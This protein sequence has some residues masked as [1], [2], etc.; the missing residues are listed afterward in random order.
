MKGGDRIG[1]SVKQTL[2]LDFFKNYKVLAGHGGLNNQ[3]QGVAIFDAPDGYLWTKHDEFVISSGYVFKANPNL[4]ETFTRSEEFTRIACL[5]IKIGRYIDEV[6]QSVLNAFNDAN[7]PLL[8]VD[9]KHSWMEVNNALLV[10]VMNKNIERFHLGQLRSSH[11]SNYSYQT[12]KTKKILS[13]LEDELSYPAMLYD[14]NAKKTYF[15]SDQFRALSKDLQL[16]DFWQPSFDFSKETLCNTL[17]M[18]RYRRFIEDYHKPYSWI[19]VPITVD[20]SVYAYFVVLEAHKIIDH[21]DQFALRTGFLLIQEIFEQQL[22]AQIMRGTAFTKFIKEITS[23]QLTDKSRISDYAYS[24]NLNVND[25]FYTVV[26]AQRDESICFSGYRDYINNSI[27]SLFSPRDCR[28]ALLDDAHCLLLFRKKPNIDSTTAIAE[29]LRALKKTLEAP[30]YGFIVT[31][32]FADIASSLYDLSKSYQRAVRTLEFGKIIY[33]NKYLW[34]YCELGP[35]A[36]FSMPKEECDLMLKDFADLIKDES[37]KTKLE[38]F[39]TYLDC[40][41]NYS[42]TAKT[43]YMHINTVRSHITKIVKQTNIDLNNPIERMKTEVLLH[44][45]LNPNQ[46]DW[47]K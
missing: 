25:D 35:F 36:W 16:D 13:A 1:I 44:L 32:G 43:C 46:S 8:I 22:M 4:F 33:P 3:I 37:Q 45:L 41:M 38:T 30:R 6:P 24:L 5:G 17:K 47:T 2:E 31:F 39:K 12:R 11:I 9:P 14:I 26:M 28:F 19:T 34:S 29:K 23:Q 27:K 15:S 42:L 40:N 20:N 21:F 10:A 7:I 18:V